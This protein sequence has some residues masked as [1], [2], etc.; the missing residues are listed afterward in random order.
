MAASGIEF[1][2]LIADVMQQRGVEALDRG[3]GGQGQGGA[4]DEGGGGGAVDADSDTT[5]SGRH[6]EGA[7]G[8]AEG[9][10]YE[11]ADLSVGIDAGGEDFVRFL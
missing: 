8:A 11:I 4:R 9:V 7:A 3:A 10:Q 6:E 1:V 5:S 2:E